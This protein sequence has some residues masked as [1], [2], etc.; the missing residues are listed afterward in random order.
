MKY[1]MVTLTLLLTLACKGQTRETSTPEATSPQSEAAFSVSKTDAEWRAQLDDMA[2]YVLRKA[3][4]EPQGSSE[5]LH[6]K[7]KGTYVCAGCGTPLFES[8]Y[9]YDSGSGWP[10]FDR[11]V[12]LKVLPRE[13]L[14]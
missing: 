9:K 6:N 12:A 10:S 11:E 8:T 5:L 7:E 4:T 3:G 1:Y 13:F 2:Y 14:H